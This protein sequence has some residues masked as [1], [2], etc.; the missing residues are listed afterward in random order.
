MSAK[1]ITV[2]LTEGFSPTFYL[3]LKKFSHRLYQKYHVSLPWDL[4][5]CNVKDK[6]E[7]VLC[8]G[9]FDPTK[10]NF[11]S[12]IH[13]M[14]R[15]E[16]TKTI[17]KK[18]RPLDSLDSPSLEL[19]RKNITHSNITR[20]ISRDETVLHDARDSYMSHASSLCTS[21]DSNRFSVDLVNQHLTP[22]VLAYTWLLYS[23]G[24]DG[25]SF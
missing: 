23:R 25:L 7:E 17:S 4:F 15:N 13:S 2:Y 6:V 11:T 8:Q 9:V 21:F 19:I 24:I 5:Y 20:H 10:G 16:G 14:I 1:D 22:H 18:H 12:F 3:N